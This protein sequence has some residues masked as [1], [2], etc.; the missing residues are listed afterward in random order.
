MLMAFT[1]VAI[2]IAVGLFGGML[3]MQVVGRRLGEHERRLDP[4]GKH[5]GATAA[6]A[7]VVGL[8]GLLVAFTFSGAGSRFDSRRNLIVD[9]TNAIGT[10]YLRIDLLPVDRQPQLRDLFRKY[11]DA[12][13]AA[14]RAV[15][16]M[17]AVAAALA[18]GEGLQRE[19]WS[20]SVAGARETGSTPAFTLL[21]PSLNEMIDITTTRT[22]A[23]RMHPPAVV[24]I[25]LALLA[26]VAAI[27]AGYGMAGRRVVSWIHRFGFALVITFAVYLIINFEFP[28]LGL[29][30][31]EAY[32]QLLVNLRR[33]MN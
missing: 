4:D 24:Y 18:K 15:P 16:D 3:V 8:L 28:R 11:V 12:R 27:F 10:A 32:D 33:S 20:A 31:V 29:M 9:E 14:Y 5:D 30:R 25:I 21:L 1:L 22:A 17:D 2:L 26:L 7:A 23:A 13:I 6:E 19:I